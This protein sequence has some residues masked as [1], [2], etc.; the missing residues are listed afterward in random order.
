MGHRCPLN[1]Y[2]AWTAGEAVAL[3]DYKKITKER[4]NRK[5]VFSALLWVWKITN[6]YLKERK[7]S[8]TISLRGSIDLRRVWVWINEFR[9][10]PVTLI[11]FEQSSCDSLTKR[12]KP[13]LHYPKHRAHCSITC[14]N[15]IDP[16]CCGE[17]EKM[18]RDGDKRWVD[19]SVDQHHQTGCCL[20]QLVHGAPPLTEKTFWL[21]ETLKL[22]ATEQI[23]TTQNPMWN[24]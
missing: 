8:Q 6:V 1:N 13:G 14:M 4:A 16:T 20:K 21:W 9:W 17:A 10:K 3:R 12:S 5:T 24:S 19:C 22:S 18:Y 11:V 2:R 15:P 7:A 23:K